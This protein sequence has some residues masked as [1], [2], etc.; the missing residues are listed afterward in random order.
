MYIKDEKQE[1]CAII[2]FKMKTKKNRK[3]LKKG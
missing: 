3:K 1:N 2:H